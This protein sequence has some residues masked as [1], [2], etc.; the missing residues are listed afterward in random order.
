VRRWA[1]TGVDGVVLETVKVGGRRFT[2]LE[3][4]ERFL[5]RINGHPEFVA[6][7]GGVGG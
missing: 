3:A 2:S 5:S 4:I 6:G 7:A 1:D